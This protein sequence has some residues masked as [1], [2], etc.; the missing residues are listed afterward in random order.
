[1]EVDCL[2]TNIIQTICL[3]C[4]LLLFIMMSLLE[5]CWLSLSIEYI[6]LCGHDSYVLVFCKHIS[7]WS[8]FCQLNW[9]YL[10]R[11][12]LTSSTCWKQIKS[13]REWNLTSSWSVGQVCLRLTCPDLFMYCLPFLNLVLPPFIKVMSH[14]N[15]PPLLLTNTQTTLLHSARSQDGW[16]IQL[17]SC[18]PWSEDF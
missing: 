3:L 15:P 16:D 6:D 18:M 17:S 1:M 10:E 14:V 9:V 2:V 12:N 5:P 11:F 7:L 8:V 13:L 4:L